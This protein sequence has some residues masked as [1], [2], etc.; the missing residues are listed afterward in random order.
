MIISFYKLINHIKTKEPKIPKGNK[1]K[2]QTDKALTNTAIK[3][4]TLEAEALSGMAL[5]AI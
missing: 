5:D 1:P 3:F 2:I 4:M